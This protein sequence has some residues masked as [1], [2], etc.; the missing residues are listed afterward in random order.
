MFSIGD[1]TAKD[2]RGNLYPM[3]A[4]IHDFME[5][6]PD[7]SARG[8][9]LLT[10]DPKSYEVDISTFIYYLDMAY[11]KIYSMFF[12]G[13]LYKE[14]IYAYKYDNLRVLKQFIP[15]YNLISDASNGRKD[16]GA[17]LNRHR[18]KYGNNLII[19]NNRYPRNDYLLIDRRYFDNLEIK[20]GQDSLYDELFRS[21]FTNL[22]YIDSP[23][24]K[25]QE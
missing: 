3:R 14:F 1:L 11:K 25:G 20:Y 18:Y 10:A 21:E 17:Y 13:D 15:A 6:F 16:F 2:D 22:G 8:R 4:G 5:I 7:G 23:F 24:S 19:E 12:E 9:I